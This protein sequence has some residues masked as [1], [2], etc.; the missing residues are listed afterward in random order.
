M[1]FTIGYEGA[2]LG[3]FTT[4]LEKADVSFL[5]DI[6]DRAQSRRPG[7]SKL[8]LERALGDSGIR[9]VHLRQLGDPKAGR[10]AARAGD[11][12]TFRR[13]FSAVLSSD[14]GQLAVEAIARWAEED[15]VCLL[16][17]ER[18]PDE[19]HRKLVS[20][21]VEAL[22]H[23]RTRHLGVQPSGKAGVSERRVRDSRQGAAA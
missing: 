2:T 17:Y 6:R 9:Y 3:D 16:C 11:F 21:A 20:Q 4:T 13:I 12:L 22:T 14:V 10:D 18:N 19:C 5:V 15:N 8:A 23:E 7:F 1:L